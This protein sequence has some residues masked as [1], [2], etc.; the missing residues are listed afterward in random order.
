MTQN[1]AFSGL[2][3]ENFG[4]TPGASTE[5]AGEQL[6]PEEETTKIG[7]E[8]PGAGQEPSAGKVVAA[9]PRESQIAV[10][11]RG[12][13]LFKI[14]TRAYGRYDRAIL[15]AVLEENPEIED[16]NQIKVGQVIKL[17]VTT[18]FEP[19]SSNL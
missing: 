1:V 5:E 6:A 19:L 13:N 18:E 14:I 8:K 17:P 2:I 16:P 9:P 12:D 11:K 4:P 10:V 3:E 7:H 15:N